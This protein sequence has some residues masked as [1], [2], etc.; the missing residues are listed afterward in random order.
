[1]FELPEELDK[2]KYFGLYSLSSV[3]KKKGLLRRTPEPNV[4]NLF[5][6]REFT[7][8]RIKLECLSLA[9]LS[10]LVYSLWARPGVHPRVEHLKDSSIG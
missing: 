8:I 1:M 5:F 10:S 4:I 3:T 9:S 7:N 6:C 2:G